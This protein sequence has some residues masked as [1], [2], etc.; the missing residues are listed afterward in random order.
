MTL[1]NFRQ[2]LGGALLASAVATAGLLVACQTTPPPSG[3]VAAP[4]PDDQVRTRGTL[5]GVPPIST[6]VPV[7]VAPGLLAPTLANPRAT[8]LGLTTVRIDWGPYTGTLQLGGYLVRRAD[9]TKPLAVLAPNAAF[10]YVD[11][12]LHD[13]RTYSYTI[14]AV[15][16]SQ[17]NQPIQVT[18]PGTILGGGGSTPA[19]Y[20][21]QYPP[22]QYSNPVSVTTPP[23]LPPASLTVSLD[24]SNPALVH[25]T[26]PPVPAAQ[27]FDVNRDGASIG[28]FAGGP[29]TDTLPGPGAYTYTVNSLLQ[30]PSGLAGS[31]STGAVTIHSGQLNILAF[32]DSIMWGQ[33]LLDQDKFSVQVRNWLAQNLSVPVG[34]ISLA[35]SGANVVPDPND[36]SFNW[37]TLEQSAADAGQV[38]NRFGEVPN[39]YPTITFQALTMGPKLLDATHNVDLVLVDGC[40]NDVNL[41]TVV[42][43]Q[44]TDQTIQSLV[45]T[46]CQTDMTSLVTTIAQTYPRARIVVTGYYPAVSA[47][48]DT[49]QLALETTGLGLDA[50]MIA[51]FVPFSPVDPLTGAIIGAILGAVLPHAA[52]DALKPIEIDHTGTFFAGSSAALQSVV[53]GVNAAGQNRANYAAPVFQDVNAFG[54]GSSSWLWPVPQITGAQDEAFA[55]RQ[56]ICDSQKQKLGSKY[57]GCVLAS[58]SHPNVQGAQQYAAA[59]ETVLTPSMQGWRAML[60]PTQTWS[61]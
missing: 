36:P 31:P 15:Q 30:E 11:N 20:N 21:D 55:V 6:A 56:Q 16:P 40:G 34:L 35:H 28:Q 48:S 2:R 58:M 32:G 14:E 52:T 54:A 3:D 4:A 53:N 8:V 59:I 39:T 10:S 38:P 25:I 37:G 26:F 24:A 7:R 12:T 17:T 1:R 50:G 5:L 41:M 46:Y 19:T 60:Q 9:V 44:T 45:N 49:G 61:R 47:K 27:T 43:P 18:T 42:N 51:G 23:L 13:N 33:G 57:P 22:A 29:V